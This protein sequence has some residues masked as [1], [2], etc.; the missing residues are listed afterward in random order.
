[1]ELEG[2]SPTPGPTPPLPTQNLQVTPE[3]VI[4]LAT[5]FREC[6][7]LLAPV[8]PTA[9]DVMRIEHPWLGDP[10]SDWAKEQFNK[11]FADGENSFAGI[12]EAEFAQHQAMR[13]ALVAT[14]KQYGLIEELT[15]AGFLEEGPPR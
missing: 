1:M 14:A 12:L 11:Y 15:A 2:D 5:M 9:R 6:A 8:A 13:D 4:E 7:Y 10:V 3:N